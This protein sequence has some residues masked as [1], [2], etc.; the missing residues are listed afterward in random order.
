MELSKGNAANHLC[1]ATAGLLVCCVLI[2][3][4]ISTSVVAQGV[5]GQPAAAPQG[6]AMEKLKGVWV[7]GPG[8]DIKY[9]VAYDACSARCLATPSCA[10]IEYYRP[11]K[12]CNMYNTVR[13]RLP[14]GASDVAIRK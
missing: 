1:A 7:D 13:P 9:G 2:A 14:G 10:M 11:Q 6:A 8:F 5:T 4:F 3:A 12:K